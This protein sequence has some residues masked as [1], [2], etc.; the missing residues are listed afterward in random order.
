MLVQHAA[1]CAKHVVHRFPDVFPSMRSNKN[2]LATACPLK[3]RMRIIRPDGM[4]HRINYRVAGNKNRVWIFSLFSQIFG[5]HSSRSE[6]IF[7]DNPN[8]LTVKLFRKRT[9]EI[10]SAKTCLH[11]TDRNL[12]IETCQ[13]R[14]KCRRSI[15]MNQY[16]IRFYLFQNRLNFVQYIRSN[17]KQS[18]LFF[19]DFQIII[20]SDAKRFQNLIQHLPVLP[21]HTYNCFYTLSR[22]Q[23]PDKR[24]HLDSFRSC[25]ENQHYLFHPDS[26][27]N[28]H[29]CHILNAKARY[30][31]RNLFSL[32]FAR[33]NRY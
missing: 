12:Q 25:A 19:H 8:C 7:A 3:L 31:F 32:F 2:Q 29:I 24:T 23:F 9:I 18:L 27:R 16:N 21:C 5:C 33:F 10:V 30:R 14:R 15:S 22:F 11:M 1:D 28:F 4:L 20:R 26:P 6:I 17:I 13:R